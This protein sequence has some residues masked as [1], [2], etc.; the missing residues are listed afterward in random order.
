MQVQESMSMSMSKKIMCG[1]IAQN[2]LPCCVMEAATHTRMLQQ[3]LTG[4]ICSYLVAQRA[5]PLRHLL[6]RHLLLR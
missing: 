3:R 5:Q 6:L 4:S 2:S 1:A